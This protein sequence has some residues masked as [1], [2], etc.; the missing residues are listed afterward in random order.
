MFP[1]RILL[2]T[3]GSPGTEAAVETAV[4]LA[5]HTGSE[6]HVMR[7]VS[8]VVERPY[9]ALAAKDRVGS[10]LEHRKML[11]LV[12]LDEQV[13]TAEKLGGSVAG[14]YY[15]EGKLDKEAIRLAEELGAGLIVTGGRELGRLHKALARILPSLGDSAESTLHRSR[16]P[17]LVVRT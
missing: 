8:L 10:M 15:R 3:D 17:V 7:S 11:A 2:A 14:S 1:T 4:E 16:R 6:L 5:T 13:G 9:P 12:A